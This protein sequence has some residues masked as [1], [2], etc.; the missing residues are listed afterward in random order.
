MKEAPRFLY[1]SMRSVSPFLLLAITACNSGL[2]LSIHPGNEPDLE[3]TEARLLVIEQFKQDEDWGWEGSFGEVPAPPRILDF[4][5]G[6]L[7]WSTLDPAIR[8]LRKIEFAC[9]KIATENPDVS[10]YEPRMS[11]LVE[12]DNGSQAAMVDFA[13]EEG[14]AGSYLV[15]FLWTESGGYS[16]RR[17]IWARGYGWRPNVEPELQQ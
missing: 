3:W 8:A 17:M 5:S 12:I 6:S 14:L 11:P 13:S 15:E 10:D 16:V 2:P 4:S 1:M 7:E 9:L